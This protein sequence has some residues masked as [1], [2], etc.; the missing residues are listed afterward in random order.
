MRILM[1]ITVVIFMSIYNVLKYIA[2]N[3]R[4]FA[5]IVCAVICFFVNSSFSDVKETVAP[6][7]EEPSVIQ[8]VIP[9]IGYE[10]TALAETFDEVLIE[11]EDVL[12]EQEEDYLYDEEVDTFTVDDIDTTF[13][14]DSVNS[15]E[16][17]RDMEIILSE[18][19]NYDF[20]LEDDAWKY[21]LI[22]K[23]HPVPDDYECPLG[24]IKGNMQC[25]ERI[26]NSLFEMMSDAR[27]DGVTLTV[28]SPYREYNKQTVLFNRK[29]DKYMNKGYSYLEAYKLASRSVTVPGA[30]EHQIGLAIDFIS[31]N[32]TNLDSG[33][34][35]CAAGKWLKAHSYEYGFILRYPEDKEDITGIIFEPWHFR[36]VGVE[37]ATIITMD[38]ITLEEFTD[39][40][41]SE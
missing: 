27:L 11:D 5:V 24:T 13:D 30:S 35:D 32:Y 37:A 15:K 3:G 28:C 25:D 2:G 36:Y 22:N 4:R 16:D 17:D 33:F 14:S 34:A 9:V 31:N 10:E 1:L 21:I 8:E 26:I 40:Y 18:Y 7:E 12:E 6:K 39:L 20:S 38:E 41:I 23:Q 19:R 29:I